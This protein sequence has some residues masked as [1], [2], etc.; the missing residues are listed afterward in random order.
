[1]NKFDMRGW[2]M[3]EY[4]FGNVDIEFNTNRIFLLFQILYRIESLESRINEDNSKVSYLAESFKKFKEAVLNNKKELEEFNTFKNDAENNNMWAEYGEY[5]ASFAQTNMEELQ[6]ASPQM[7]VAI[8][9]LLDTEFFKD[10][11]Q[12]NQ[13]YTN[14]MQKRFIEQ[15]QAYRQNAGNI[16]GDTN[17]QKIIYMPFTPELFSVEPC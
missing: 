15:T 5:I 9:N 7:A 10:V 3:S 1:M 13:Q 8:R 4:N 2:I 14:E 11:E 16:I 12:M 17:V 6:S